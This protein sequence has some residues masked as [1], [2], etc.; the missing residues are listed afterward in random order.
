MDNGSHQYSVVNAMHI[1]LI[2]SGNISG[3][4]ARAARAIPGLTISAVYGPHADRVERLAAE[5][6][7]RPYTDLE[8]FLDH[9]PMEMVAIGTPSGL[10]AAHGIEASQRGLH[11]LVEKP[12]D[13]T[14]SRADA[15]IDAARA[16]GVKLAVFFQ[17]RFAPGVRR[18][19]RLVDGGGL[20]RLL[21]ASARVKWFRPPE[22][23]SGSS[24]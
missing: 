6:D 9:R 1:G 24:W 11:V 23:Y 3:T 22:Y 12:I 15:L 18:L 20:G 4:H 21:L 5:H 7:A 14:T 17:D 19:K 8:R 13:V 2:G 16:S 10:H